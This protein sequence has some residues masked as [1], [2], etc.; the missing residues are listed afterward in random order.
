MPGQE[1]FDDIFL[2]QI[3]GE[4]FLKLSK[5]MFAIKEN[6]FFIQNQFSLGNITTAAAKLNS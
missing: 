5:E 3:K 4:K 2:P 1:F 6:L